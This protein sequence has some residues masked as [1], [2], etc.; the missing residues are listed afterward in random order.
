MVVPEAPAVAPER[1]NRGTD[2]GIAGT[3]VQQVVEL[4]VQLEEIFKT[5]V[6]DGQCPGNGCNFTP[7][8][9]RGIQGR[10]MH[11]HPLQDHHP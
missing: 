7:L 4:R 8:G 9:V 6:G 2:K 10:A 5:V 11:H 3:N 1:R